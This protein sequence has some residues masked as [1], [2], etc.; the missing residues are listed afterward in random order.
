M[1]SLEGNAGYVLVEASDPKVIAMFVTKYIF[2]NDIR[3]VPV[4]D[5]GDVVPIVATSVAWARNA[6]KS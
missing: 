2:W 5:V 4:I 6:S 3:V 1:S